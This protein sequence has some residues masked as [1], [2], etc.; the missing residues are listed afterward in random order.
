MK[1]NFA[2]AALILG[3]TLSAPSANRA[4]AL[5]LSWLK[6][7][8]YVRCLQYVSGLSQG[9]P[10]KYDRGRRTCNRTYFPNRPGTQY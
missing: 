9:D 8:N 6:N 1:M 7:E 5:D 2:A 4:E 10:V 3:T